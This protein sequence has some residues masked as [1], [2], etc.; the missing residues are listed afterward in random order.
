[1]GSAVGG[2][3]G[4]A[5]GGAFT[6]ACGDECD[7]LSTFTVVGVLG[8]GAGALTGALVGLMIPERSWVGVSV[9]PPLDSSAP[10]ASMTDGAAL[11][12]RVRLP[13]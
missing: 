5:G 2:G 6:L 9:E 12:V 10:G 3:L 7:G 13:G 1:M 4:L 8:A 11:L